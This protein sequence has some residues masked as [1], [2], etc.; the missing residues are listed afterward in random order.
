MYERM[1]KVLEEDALNSII[2][3]GQ[4]LFAADGEQ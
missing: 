1:G 2:G 3:E 4:E